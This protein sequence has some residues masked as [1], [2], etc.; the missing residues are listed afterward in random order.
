MVYEER[1]RMMA[2][3]T[4]LLLSMELMILAI[5]KEKD[6]Y[7]W[8]LM[9]IIERDTEKMFVPKMG[10]IYPVLYDLLDHGYITSYEI[11]IKTKARI[12][13]HLEPLG[14]QYFKEELEKY[15]K[16]VKMISAVIYRNEK[17]DNQKAEG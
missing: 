16:L 10:S 11:F 9:R 13:Y 4:S 15:T 3:K 7:G 8:E 14:E 5:L 6:C 1:M 17:E 2:N 12:Y